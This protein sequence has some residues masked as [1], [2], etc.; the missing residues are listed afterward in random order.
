[1]EWDLC[2]SASWVPF[3][4]YTM[5]LNLPV[6]IQENSIINQKVL[7]TQSS[8]I[9][10]CKQHT[11]KPI[12][13]T[14]WTFSPVKID[15]FYFLSGGVKHTATKLRFC[16]FWLGKMHWKGFSG[17]YIGFEV[18]WIQWCCFWVSMIS[19]SSQIQISGEKHHNSE[20][21]CHTKF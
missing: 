7:V 6:K 2:S 9:V 19:R 14:L 17:A 10:H 5:F 1:M 21:T 12:L 13:K 4:S 11:Q 16:W 15:I 3:H 20:S 8:N 18:C